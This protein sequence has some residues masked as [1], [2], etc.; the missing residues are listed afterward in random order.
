MWICPSWGVSS[1]TWAPLRRGFLLIRARPRAPARALADLAVFATSGEAAAVDPLDRAAFTPICPAIVQGEPS[2]AGLL[3]S[4]PTPERPCTPPKSTL[5][6]REGAPPA[7]RCAACSE[8]L[9][10]RR[11]ALADPPHRM[12]NAPS[13]SR[14]GRHSPREGRQRT[15]HIESTGNR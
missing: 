9:Q 10:R 3:L 4:P 1:L 14:T 15:R 5:S 8:P 2:R 13:G 6:T 7:V 12:T 11:P